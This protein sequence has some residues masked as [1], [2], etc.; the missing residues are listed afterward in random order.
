MTR[1]QTRTVWSFFILATSFLELRGLLSF[2]SSMISM[3]SLCGTTCRVG[4]PHWWSQEVNSFSPNKWR[5]VLHQKGDTAEGQ[6][7]GQWQA[8]DSCFS[9]SWMEMFTEFRASIWLA[10][11]QIFVGF[12]PLPWLTWPCLR[13]YSQPAA[14]GVRGKMSDRCW[15]MWDSQSP[16]AHEC[17]HRLGFPGDSAVKNPP[18][19]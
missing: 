11:R 10:I 12:G 6:K 14:H 4:T 17:T 3:V 15:G 7:S 5:D 2:A 9:Q 1:P 16:F 13:Y 8:S 19:C 18:K